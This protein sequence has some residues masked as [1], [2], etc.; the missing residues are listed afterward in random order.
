MRFTSKLF[1]MILFF[2]IPVWATSIP[3]DNLEALHLNWLDNKV[4][5][6]QNFFAYA[7]GT[8]QKENPIPPEYESWGT[9]SVLHQKIQ[10]I[11]HKM[12]IEAANN[13]KAKPGSI[14]QKVGDF[15]FSGMDEALINQLGATPLTRIFSN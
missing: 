13:T 4:L 11:V 7:N 8:W 10:K 5:P 14:E 6:S 2:S 15:Y 12:L 9:F 1:T 3:N